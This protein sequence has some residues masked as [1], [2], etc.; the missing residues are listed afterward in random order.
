MTAVKFESRNCLEFLLKNKFSENEDQ[1]FLKNNKIYEKIIRNNSKD[2]INIKKD[3]KNRIEKTE[4]IKI[5]IIKEKLK[6]KV[7]LN[8]K[9]YEGKTALHYA[10]LNE[11]VF[12]VYKLLVKGADFK[13]KNKKNLNAFEIS[14]KIKN[15]FIRKLFVF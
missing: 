5:Q 12:M 3:K 10:V 14:K 8:L 11:D 15:K 13:I 4:K 6:N 9:D 2:D 7:N 1:D